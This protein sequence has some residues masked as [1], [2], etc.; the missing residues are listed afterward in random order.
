MT[1]LS[2]KGSEKML[3]L[4]EIRENRGLT[5][6][7][8]ADLMGLHHMTISKY[9]RGTLKLD[10]DSIIKFSEI[11]EVTPNDLLG[12]EISLSK[13]QEHLNNLK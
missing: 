13:Y 11:L 1:Y 6:H 8:L 2:S 5:Q 7:Q 3:R 9:E 4:K 12:F 10:Q